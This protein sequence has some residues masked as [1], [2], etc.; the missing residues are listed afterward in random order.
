[1]S[2][3][4]ELLRLRFVT[5]HPKDL[6]DELI[7]CFHDIK[8]L[9]PHIHL[10]FQAG[11]NRVLKL[12]RR[13]YTRE[14]YLELIKKLRIVQP[15]IA[16]TSDVMVGF[17]GETDDDFQLTLDL[18][19]HVRFDSLFSFKYSDRKGTSADKMGGKI[20]DIVKASRLDIL[21]SLQKGI[22]FEKNK[23]FEGKQLEILVEGKSKKGDSSQVG[24]VLIK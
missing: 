12:M 22:T 13:G 10:P 1:M 15:G 2:R 18:I 3:L 24:Q 16:I 17:P 7:A 6:S 9:C 8:I 21:Q 11:S 20:D 23:A 14:S 4:D 19:R 5:S